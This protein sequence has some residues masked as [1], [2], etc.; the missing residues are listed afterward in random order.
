MQQDEKQIEKENK[1]N[2][3]MVDVKNKTNSE[4]IT[5]ICY[6]TSHLEKFKNPQNGITCKHCFVIISNNDESMYECHLE[7]NCNWYQVTN[8]RYWVCMDCFSKNSYNESTAQDI[9]TIIQNKF[10]SSMTVIS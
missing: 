8:A 6:C 7:T 2:Q 10:S 1:T 5:S 3:S 9:N 4:N